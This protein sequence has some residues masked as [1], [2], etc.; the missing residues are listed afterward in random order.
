MNRYVARIT[1][2]AVPALALS[3]LAFIGRPSDESQITLRTVGQTAD[4]LAAVESLDRSDVDIT[5]SVSNPKKSPIPAVLF[6]TV[7]VTLMLAVACGAVNFVEDMI[8]KR[9]PPKNE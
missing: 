1:A 8:L 9:F 6:G 5:V 2:C 4:I 7:G 3:L